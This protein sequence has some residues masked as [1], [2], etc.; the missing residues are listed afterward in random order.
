MLLILT[1]AIAP[2]V[3]HKTYK[4]YVLILLV[5]MLAHYLTNYGRCGLTSMEMLL[6]GDQYQSGFLY[7]LITP[8]ITLPESYLDAGLYILHGIWIIVLYLQLHI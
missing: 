6:L 4:E 8:I 2:I 5:F 7:R 1:I 3:P